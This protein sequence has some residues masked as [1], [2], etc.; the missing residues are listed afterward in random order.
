MSR[1]LS[2]SQ[3]HELLQKLESAGLNPEVAQKI[4]TSKGNS[5][6]KKVVEFLKNELK[7][8]EKVLQFISFICVVKIQP[9]K[10][11]KVGDFFTGGSISMY[12]GD[13]FKSW[14]LEKSKDLELSSEE[15]TLLNKF[16]LK[17]DAWDTEIHSD[18]EKKPV[19]PVKIFLP[20]LKALLEAQPKGEFSETGLDN[21]GKSNIFNID[22]TEINPSLGVVAVYVYWFGA[23]W[24]CLAYSLDFSFR[25]NADGH[26]FSLATS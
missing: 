1:I 22:L 9:V 25:W 20:L 15:E 13:N 24:R 4:I 14:I 6:A 18:F 11:F 10:K 23:E 19:I 2:I 17:K 12:F 21:S 8:V 16:L 3:E 26:F 5:L 7:I